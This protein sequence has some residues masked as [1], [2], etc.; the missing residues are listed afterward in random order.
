M[1][2]WYVYAL[3]DEKVPARRIRGRSIHA[4]AAGGVFAMAERAAAA[5]ALSEETLVRQ[6]EIVTALANRSSAI[7]PARFGSL[8]ADDELRRVIDLQRDRIREAFDLVRGCEQMTLRLIGEGARD[9]P[10]AA[11]GAGAGPPGTRYLKQRRA[12]AGYPLPRAVSRI[13]KA[14]RPF[15]QAERSEPGQ[16]GVRAMMYHLIRRGR[17]RAYVEAV[18]GVSDAVLPYTVKVTGPF[19]PFA[20]APELLA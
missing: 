18:A 14:L 16:G 11:A 17:T 2:S 7:L 5:P 9:V 8:L 13:S 10:A 4:V 19:P 6:H 12:A 15:V 1:R 3:V 20:F